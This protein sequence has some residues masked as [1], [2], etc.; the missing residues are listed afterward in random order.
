MGNVAEL[1]ERA[2]DCR[3]VVQLAP[4]IEAFRVH[5]ARRGVVTLLVRQAPTAREQLG[6][7]RRATLRAD[8]NAQL[9]KPGAALARMA[10]GRPELPQGS[11][12][13]GAHVQSAMVD[14]PAQ[15]GA[16]VVVLVLE[17]LAPL[18]PVL[19]HQLASGPFAQLG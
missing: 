17:A 10:A 8:Q 11:A 18:S 12:Q 6:L 3:Q 15:A 9:R 1:A 16:Q 5:C 4:D 13:A 2:G 19:A 7:R 14:A